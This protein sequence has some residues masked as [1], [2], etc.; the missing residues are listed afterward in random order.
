MDTESPPPGS[1]QTDFVCTKCQSDASATDT[2]CR[3]CGALFSDAIFCV[4]HGT[5]TAAGVCVICSQACCKKCGGNKNGV[6]LCDLHWEYEIHEGLARVF[7]SIDNVQAQY[8]TS[9]LEQAGYHPFLYSRRF[10]PGAGM[11]DTWVRVGIRNYGKHP[12]VEMKVLV[13]FSEVLRAEKS[14]TELGLRE[15]PTR[16]R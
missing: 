15:N 3:N 8:V 5:M 9:C 4:N 12:I 2:F 6:F 16:E 1:Q 10:N 13:P 14:L 7:G 11:I